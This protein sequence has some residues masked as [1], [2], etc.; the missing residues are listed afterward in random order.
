M[1]TS[2]EYGDKEFRGEVTFTQQVNLP[3]VSIGNSQISSSAANRIDR[4]KV[5]HQFS[6]AYQ[7]RA[8]RRVA[9]SA[10]FNIDNGSGVTID[11][12]ILVPGREITIYAARIVY[13]TETT[14]TVAAGNAK[15]GTTVGG[16]EIVAATAYGNTKTVGQTTAM[17]L[18][19][20]SGV[21]VAAGTPVIARH[22]GIA[23]TAAGEAYV[24]IEY[25][26]DDGADVMEESVVLY[27]CF[28]A[29][30]VIVAFE[31]VIETAATSSAE[32]TVDLHKSTAGGAFATVLSSP[33]TIDSTT[34]VR[35]PLA[36]ALGSTAL[37]DGDVLK[38]IVS[39]TNFGGTLP[40]GLSFNLVTGEAP[41]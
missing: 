38:A 18:T 17:V 15:I 7:Q 13:T 39:I 36:A 33:I 25:V 29:S 8:V 31:A 35:T 3:N 14:G 27:S 26:E 20:A 4:T 2:V 9:R 5:V 16:A 28:G 12:V 11:S 41:N 1:A 40:T 6:R 24:E 23:T 37:V 21:Q 32:I 22:T 34:V 19:T 10:L 30:G